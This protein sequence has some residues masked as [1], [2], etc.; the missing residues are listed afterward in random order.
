[1]SWIKIE[2]QIDAQKLSF[3]IESSGVYQFNTRYHVIKKED[4]ITAIFLLKDM[5]I[6]RTEDRDFHYGAKNVPWFKDDRRI[7]NIDAY[8]WNGNHIWNIGDIVGDV[9]MAFDVGSLTTRASVQM[10]GTLSTVNDCS[11]DLFYCYAGPYRYLID[12][13]R[14]KILEKKSGK[15]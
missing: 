8:E 3:E 6:I 5:I 2:V 15:W 12:P 1:M 10:Q 7:N 9:K 4:K 11:F 13:A 14:G